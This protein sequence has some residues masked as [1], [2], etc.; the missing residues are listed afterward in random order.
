[1]ELNSNSINARLYRWFYHKHTNQMPK[2]LCPY[3]WQLLIMYV[4]IVPYTLFTLPYHLFNKW[5]NESF[6]SGIAGSFVVYLCLFGIFTM[7]SF[8]TFLFN[9]LPEKGFWSNVCVS[10]FI[11]WVFTIGGLI[12]ELTKYLWSKSREKSKT[13]TIDKKPNIIV[14]FIKAKYNRYCPK[15]TWK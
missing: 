7:F 9:N 15:I 8:V 1:M 14:E 12:S 3:F 2:S 5:E 11:L 13:T 6:V 10:G 4:F